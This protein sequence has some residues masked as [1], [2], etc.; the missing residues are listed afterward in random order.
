M[1]QSSEYWECRHDL[2]VFQ[3]SFVNLGSLELHRNKHRDQKD[4]QSDEDNGFSHLLHTIVAL[5]C[6]YLLHF[7]KF[8]LKYNN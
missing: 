3:L 5:L 4:R 6:L 2:P 1:S 8:G 7:P